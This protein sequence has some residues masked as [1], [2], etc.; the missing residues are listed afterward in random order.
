MKVIHL[1][2][3]CFRIVFLAILTFGAVIHF[4]WK[5]ALISALSVDNPTLPF[6][7]AEELIPSPYQITLLK[8]SSY[9]VLFESARVDPLMTIWKSKFLDKETSLKQ[10]KE[11]MMPLVLSGDYVMYEAEST[12][13]TYPEYKDCLITD[14]GFALEKM[15]FGF[16]VS[17]NSQYRDLFN[18]MMKKMIETGTLAR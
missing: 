9:Q 10:T 6:R 2:L 16:A 4:H 14:L 8:D 18:F 17:K 11:E 5:A 13:Q 12:L 1:F 3:P 7:N 15:N